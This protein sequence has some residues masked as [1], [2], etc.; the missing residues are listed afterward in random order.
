MG[1]SEDQLLLLLADLFSLLWQ[2]LKVYQ[3]KQGGFPRALNSCAV[4]EVAGWG[5]GLGL[6]ILL[7]T[8]QSGSPKHIQS[9]QISHR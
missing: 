5:D 4:S 3:V 7:Y 9:D 8:L 6:A 1:G 2:G